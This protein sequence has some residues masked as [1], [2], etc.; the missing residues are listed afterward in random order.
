MTY[1]NE[2]RASQ[3]GFHLLDH[4]FVDQH[5]S[6]TSVYEVRTWKMP[7]PLPIVTPCISLTQ[8]G[9]AQSD[10]SMAQTLAHKVI[11]Q[12]SQTVQKATGGR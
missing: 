3:D 12:C 10:K 4:D 9:G 2:G 1:G 8:F 11:V 5:S 6:M 7:I